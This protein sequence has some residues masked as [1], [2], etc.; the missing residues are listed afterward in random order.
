[1]ERLGARLYGSGD[2]LRQDGVR[3]YDAALSRL[4]KAMYI[5]LEGKIK[6]WLSLRFRLCHRDI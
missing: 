6:K 1:M 5:Y 2:T 4:H 3:E